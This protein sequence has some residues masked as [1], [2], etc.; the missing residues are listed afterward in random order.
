MKQLIIMSV[1]TNHEEKRLVS[2]KRIVGGPL[3]SN[4]YI[5]YEGDEAFIVDAGVEPDK[6]L[7]AIREMGVKVR[8]IVLT[9]GHFDHVFYVSRLMDSL[10]AR[11]YIHQAD[12]T[13]MRR[14][15]I[16]GEQF[17]KEK[18]V[19]PA[20]IEKVSDNDKLTLSNKEARIIHTPGHSPGSICIHIENLLFTGDTLFRGTIGR[21][22]LPGGSEELMAQSLRKIA[23]LPQST[24]VLPGHGHESTIGYELSSNYLFR[25]MIGLE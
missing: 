23:K 16:Y 11:A 22:D 1:I 2:Y 21:T 19:E 18:F 20:S 5:V 25:K 13:V 24:R 3:A 12:I 4:T 6:V 14:S 15:S 8:F 7:G 10:G 17:Y 9:H